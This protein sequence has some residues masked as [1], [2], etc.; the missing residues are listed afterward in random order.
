VDLT[1][2]QISATPQAGQTLTGSPGPWNGSPSAY[3]YQ[4]FSCD[5]SLTTCNAIPAA[6]GSSYVVGAG[7]VGRRLIAGVIAT[8]DGGDSDPAFSDATSP[9]LPA[10]LAA[11]PVPND[12]VA[13]TISGTAQQGQTLTASPGTWSNNPTGYTYQWERCSSTG[14]NCVDIAGATATTYRAGGADVGSTLIVQVVAANAGG[15]SAP[16]SSVPTSLV[17]GPNCHVP[18]VVGL[19]LTKAKTNIRAAHCSVGRITKK[20]AKPAKRGR[21]LSQTPKHGRTLPN[22]A[23][24][25]LRIGK[26]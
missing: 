6:T 4:W 21:V 1:L 20:K 16:A 13:P 12:Q 15:N 24:V 22:G 7:D 14:T 9:I 10:P 19:K 26:P 5:T 18:N 11:P 25:S 8:N 23:K 17:L 3:S 2:P